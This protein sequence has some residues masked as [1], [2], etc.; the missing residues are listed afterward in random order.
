M[1]RVKAGFHGVQF[2]FEGREEAI[3]GGIE[4]DGLPHIVPLGLSTQTQSLYGKRF[5]EGVVEGTFGENV[6]DEAE[7]E[8]KLER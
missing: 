8:P 1:R 7:V 5:E 2:G 3:D 4:S 6:K